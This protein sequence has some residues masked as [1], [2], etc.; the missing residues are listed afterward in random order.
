MWIFF[1]VSALSTMLTVLPVSGH[2][3]TAYQWKNRVL[4]IFSPT[5]ADPFFEALNRNISEE[6]S[7]MNHRDL[8]V[9][10]V[11]ET[12]PSFIE[13]KLLSPED[14]EK[15][16]ER[17]RVRAGRFTVILIGKDGG[18]KMVRENQVE[19]R[20]IFDLI[21]GMPMRQQEMRQKGPIR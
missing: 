15:L 4:L 21:D 18:V 11:F 5:D 1:V 12:A 2:D 19:L 10:R 6:L 13:E 8:I 7:E 3:L 20:E 14:A 9:L 17:F 16:R